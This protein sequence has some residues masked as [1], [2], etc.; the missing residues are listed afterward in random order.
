MNNHR[1]L[2]GE[3]LRLVHYHPGRLRA[4]ARI[5]LDGGPD[6]PAVAAA[7]QAAVGT[8]GC[9]DFSHTPK[10]GSIVISYQPGILDP[11]DLLER[12]AAKVGLSGV[13]HD[14]ADRVHRQELLDIFLDAIKSLNDFASEATAARADLRELIPTALAITSAVSFALN[15]DHRR[16]PRWDSALWWG[17]RVFLQWHRKDIEVRS[18]PNTVGDPNGPTKETL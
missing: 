13:V 10:T 7:R 4:R 2:L 5:F 17:Y 11:D 6:T 15:P 1:P 3:P 12:L 18:G 8:P 14:T 9:V 16:L